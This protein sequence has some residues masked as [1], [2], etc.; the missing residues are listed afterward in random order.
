MNDLWDIVFTEKPGQEGLRGVR[1]ALP[2]KQ[3]VE[4]ET[5]LVHG[6]PKPVSDA[7]HGGADLVQM[8]SGNLTSAG[9]Q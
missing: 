5:V 3:D 9:P 8:G 7:I 4:H 2:L 6:P 1:I